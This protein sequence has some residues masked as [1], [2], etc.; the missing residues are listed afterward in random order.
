MFDFSRL[1]S[2]PDS[3]LALFGIPIGFLLGTLVRWLDGLLS[4]D[5]NPDE[6]EE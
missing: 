3:I 5:H 6:M 4:D 2:S 1:F